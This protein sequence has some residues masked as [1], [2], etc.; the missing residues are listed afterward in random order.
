M[1]HGQRSLGSRSKVTGVKVNL[2]LMILEDWLTPTSSYLSINCDL[3]RGQRLGICIQNKA[4][5]LSER[6]YQHIRERM[7]AIQ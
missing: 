4:T 2:R 6:F 5:C 1:G 3:S 7:E